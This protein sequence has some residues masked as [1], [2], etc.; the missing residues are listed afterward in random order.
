MMKKTYQLSIATLSASALL[1]LTGCGSGGGS[2][3]DVELTIWARPA[4]IGAD[5]E[6]NLAEQFPDWDISIS[7]MND[8]DDNLRAGLRTQSNLPDVAII[9]GN[10]PSYFEIS[11]SFLDHSEYGFDNSE[12]IVEWALPAGQDPNGRQIGLPTDIGPWGLF[13]RADKVEEMGYSSDPEELAAEIAELENYEQFAR[14]AQEAGYLACD[15]PFSYY[16]LQM[17]QNSYFYFDFDG[18][19]P[20]NIVDDPIHEAAFMRA[21]ALVDDED[22]CANVEPYSAEWNSAIAQDSLVAFVGPAYQEGIL[23]PAAGDS[24]V[25]RV[26]HTPGGPASMT[27]SYATALAPTDHPEEASQVASFLASADAMKDAYLEQGLFP[28]NEPLYEDPDLRDGDPFFGGQD[29]FGV[30]ADVAQDAVLARA[31]AGTGVIESA[32]R[33]GL[34][35]IADRG[36]DAEETYRDLVDSHLDIDG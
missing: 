15:S 31:G 13:Y 19:E 28:G 4:S 36:L 35:E 6:E 10:L 14:D 26:T 1:A 18:D 22:L 7:R 11:E 9:G 8:I 27:G 32:A 24:D 17:V 2:S 23:K 33:T 29:A 30:L 20:V 16:R 21:A 5:I 25:W 3:D 12:G 34:Q